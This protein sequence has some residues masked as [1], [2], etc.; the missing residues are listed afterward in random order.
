[1]SIAEYDQLDG[2]G[3]AALVRQR[4]VSPLQLVGEA[5]ARAERVNPTLNAI[6]TPLYEQARRAAAGPLPEGPF[7]GVPFLLKD[8]AVALAGAR[9]T[10]GSRFV[11]AYTPA[12][13][14][15]LVERYRQAGVIFLGKTNTPELGLL[16][17][18]EPALF[19]P[20]RNPW[21]TGV[22]PG[23]S[24]GGSAASVAAGVVP[25]AHGND[26]GGSIRIPASCCGLF[27]L[28]PTRGR[29]PVGPDSSELLAG[30]GI[31]HV[32]SRSVRDSAA[33]LDATAGADAPARYHAPRAA[34]PFAAEVGVPPRRLRIAVLRAPQLT[35][36]G[37][38]ALHP[39]CAAAVDDA[40]RLLIALGHDVEE[41][42][43]PIDS[44]ELAREFLI[45]MC[46]EIAVAVAAIAAAQGRRPR[47]GELEAHTLLTAMVGRQKS[48][49]RYAIARERLNAIARKAIAFSR[50]FDLTLAPTLG[51]PPIAIG[52][53]RTRG[54]EAAAESFVAATGLSILLRIPGVVQRSAKRIFDFVSFTPLA[55]VTGQP[56]MN[57]PLYWNAAGLPVGTMFTAA[58]GDE[59]TLFRLAAQLENARPWASRRPPVHAAC[60][61]P[62][63]APEVSSAA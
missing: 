38:Q 47:R 17:C 13:D 50:R 60:P 2:L 41:A 49:V 19:G 46:V 62:P 34:G 27:G 57:V 30:L 8:L 37:G 16:P 53:L 15:T 20:A 42:T 56:S 39:D 28:K 12:A 43:L 21:N 25:L 59:A 61:A 29:M 9:L 31:D 52:A 14:S 10:H 48:A 36:L 11:G 55:N 51:A 3:L 22:T 5:I 58:V 33:M 54:F 7:R 44:E 40:A 63:A 35:L 4:Q 18:T 23:G 45:L 32:I 6:V 24:S 26:G 1:M